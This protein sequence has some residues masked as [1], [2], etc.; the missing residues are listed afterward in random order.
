V[1]QSIKDIDNN[2]FNNFEQTIS[3]L[4]LQGEFWH[5]K[6]SDSVKETEDERKSERKNIL[7]L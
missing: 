5:N 3:G 4:I 2:D 1:K 7:A 6:Y